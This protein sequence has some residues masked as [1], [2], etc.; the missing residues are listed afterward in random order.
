[1]SFLH[2]FY[3]SEARVEAGDGEDD[4]DGEDDEDA[5]GS[6]HSWLESRV[7][8]EA[9]TRTHTQQQVAL[10]ICSPCVAHKLHQENHRKARATKANTRSNT[11]LTKNSIGRQ[12]H[13]RPTRQ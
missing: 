3:E 9:N 5:S 13:R 2:D 1:M 11:Y 8:S 4:V 6:G 12:E 7:G 10:I